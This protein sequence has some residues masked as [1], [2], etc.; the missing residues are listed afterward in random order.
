MG[1]PAAAYGRTPC[2]KSCGRSA[3][4]RKQ[5]SKSMLPKAAAR[6]SRSPYSAP[7]DRSPAPGFS[8]AGG[9]LGQAPTS[10]YAEPIGVRVYERAFPSGEAFFIDGDAEL[11][12][13]GIDVT[14]I[15]VDQGVRPGVARVLRE[16]EPDVPTRYGD[17]PGKAG[18]ELML[19]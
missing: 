19:P 2:A 18:L 10:G 15:E 5:S 14:H 8:Y 4:L 7:R 11:R 12:G 6:S 17:E 13:D 3:S 1:V 16:V 9:R